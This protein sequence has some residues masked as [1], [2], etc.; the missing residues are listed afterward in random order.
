MRVDMQFLPDTFVR[1]ESC[2]GLR[3]NRE[4]LDVRYRG[5]SIADVLALSAEAATQLFSAIPKL[6]QKLSVLC[7]VGLGYL[8]IGQPA[9]TLSGGEAQRVKLARELARR[10]TGKTLVVLDE[11]TTGLHFRDVALLIALLQRLI[12]AGNTVLVI[13]HHLD[14]IKVSDHVIDLGPEGG[15][16]GGEV[17]VQGTP[18]E[19]ART[20]RSH[21]GRYLAPLLALSP[22]L[23]PQGRARTHP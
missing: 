14:L 5:Y 1:C 21:T 11:P 19:V 3:Y 22:A 7:D 23:T 16:S 4:T 13:E 9:N 2:V 15:P 18:E 12:D 17:L 20:P 8:A 10:T 6:F